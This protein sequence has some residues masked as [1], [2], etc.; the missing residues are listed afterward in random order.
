MTC[1]VRCKVRRIGVAT[2]MV[3]ALI[4][5]ARGW[6]IGGHEAPRVPATRTADP[7]RGAPPPAEP[8]RQTPLRIDPDDFPL[9]QNGSVS[10]TKSPEP[11]PPPTVPASTT[12]QTANLHAEIATPVPPSTPHVRA[13]AEE[14]YLVQLGTYRLERN[15]RQDQARYRALGID[16]RLSPSGPYVVLR[17][18]SFDTLDDAKRVEQ[19]LRARGLE[20]VLLG[21]RP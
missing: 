4:M 16:C 19:E 17:L 9:V 12:A 14:H 3:L 11:A 7:W 15:A 8:V 2:G 21:P 20:P 1:K 6:L 13:E 18:P 10:V 5:V